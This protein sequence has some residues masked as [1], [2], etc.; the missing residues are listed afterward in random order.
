MLILNKISSLTVERIPD[1]KEAEVPTIYIIPD[2]TADLDKWYY[3]GV[4][5]LLKFKNILVLV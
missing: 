4:Y 3:H 1:T 5:M 2:E